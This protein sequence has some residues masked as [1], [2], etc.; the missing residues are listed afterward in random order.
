MGLGA[1]HDVTNMI[2]KYGIVPYDVYPE[3]QEEGQGLNHGELDAVMHEMVKAVIK[4]KN[5]S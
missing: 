1:F 2:R 5:K 4:N 3:I